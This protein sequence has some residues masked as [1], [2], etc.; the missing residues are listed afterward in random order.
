MSEP[1]E[2]TVIPPFTDLLGLDSEVSQDA[3]ELDDKNFLAL[4][5]YTSEDSVNPANAPSFTAESSG[6]ELAL[7][8]A[9]RSNET[10]VAESKLAGGLDKL[11]L[12]SLYE[13]AMA[14][15]ANPNG[16]YQAGQTVLNPSVTGPGFSE[17]PFFASNG[18]APP[19]DVQMTA[20][21]Q[22]H[23]PQ[24]QTNNSQDSSNPFGNPF[25]EQGVPSSYPP[26]QNPYKG[27]I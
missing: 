2:A 4:A 15:Q 5:I 6:W 3:S 20:M 17:D 10:A 7:V 21:S 18:I 19:P 1:S 13:H 12:D 11:T 23:Q 22:Q 14:R 26:P 8:G 25:L 27:F 9:P 24:H 16:A